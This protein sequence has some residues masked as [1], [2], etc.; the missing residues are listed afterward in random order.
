MSVST[1]AETGNT[2]EH[3]RL[4]E[5][6]LQQGLSLRRTASLAGIDM[7]HLSRVERGQAMPSVDVLYR[8]AGVL[9]LRQLRNALAPYIADQDQPPRRTAPTP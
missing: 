8:L 3:S 5:A 4:R 9:Y 7:A 6:R 1:R 2:Q